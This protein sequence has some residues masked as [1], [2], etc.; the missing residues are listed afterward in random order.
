MQCPKHGT[1]RSIP[2]GVSKK[3]GKPYPAFYVCTEESCTYRPEKSE[4]NKFEKNLDQE[5]VQERI[6]KRIG[7]KDTH[8]ARAVALNDA[9]A[10]LAPNAMHYVAL[11]SLDAL[12]DEVLKTADRFYTWLTN[13]GK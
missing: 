13:G 10:L 2:A 12:R 3:T 4:V 5:I 8:I 1:M 6:D 7:E 9:T 11:N